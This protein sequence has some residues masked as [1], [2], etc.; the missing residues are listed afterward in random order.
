[1]NV[2]NSIKGKDKAINNLNQVQAKFND[3][4]KALQIA[5]TKFINA[6][7]ESSQAAQNAKAAIT[8]SIN[9]QNVY[10]LVFN[11]YGKAK[12]LLTEAQEQKLQTDLNVQNARNALDLAT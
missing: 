11:A 1:M 7:G 3:T 4:T 6:Q 8:S 12:K 2:N 5:N 10:N 9:S